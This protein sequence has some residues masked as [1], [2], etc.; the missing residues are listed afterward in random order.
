MVALALLMFYTLLIS[1]SEQLGFNPAYLISA[2][3]VTLLISWYAWSILPQ[4]SLVTWVLLLQ[5]GLYL[6]LFIILQ[7]QDY[8]LLTGSIGLFIILAVIMRASQKIKW[9]A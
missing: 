8:A 5:T 7:L 3:A 1:I 9:Y 6:F 2:V 4:K